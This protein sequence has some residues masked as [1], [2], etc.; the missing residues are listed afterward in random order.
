MMMTFDDEKT[1]PDDKINHFIR[2]EEDNREMSYFKRKPL[3]NTCYTNLVCYKKNIKELS[4]H[5]KAFSIAIIK[6]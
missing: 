4:F 5:D 2:Y 3:K 6:F 1:I